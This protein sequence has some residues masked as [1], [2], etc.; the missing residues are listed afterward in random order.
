MSAGRL[1]GRKPFILI[2]QLKTKNAAIGIKVRISLF[3]AKNI[4]KTWNSSYIRVSIHKKNA[5]SRFINQYDMYDRLT[6]RI[7]GFFCRDFR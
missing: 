4:K 2:C 7:E 5:Y 6:G 1:H 3:S